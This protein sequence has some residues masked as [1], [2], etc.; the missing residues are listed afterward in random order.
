MKIFC[1]SILAVVSTVIYL[2][3]K[4]NLGA[5]V[6]VGALAVYLILAGSESK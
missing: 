2:V 6:F 3:D 1:G 4:D 5:A